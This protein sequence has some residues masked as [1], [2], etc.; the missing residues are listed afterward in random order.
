[1][2]ARVRA[3]EAAAVEVLRLLELASQVGPEELR[4]AS[5]RHAVELAKGFRIQDKDI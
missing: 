3:R 5:V 4:R 1:L 2:P